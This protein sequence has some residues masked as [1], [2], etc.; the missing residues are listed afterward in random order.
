MKT[1]LPLLSAA[2]LTLSAA[3][4]SAQTAPVAPTPPVAHAAPA[5]ASAATTPLSVET[6]PIDELIKNPKAMEILKKHLPELAGQ[7]DQLAMAGSMTL[8]DVQA[9]AAESFTNEKLAAIE[10]DF[11]ALPAN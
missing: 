7:E 10:A 11:K 6:T 5:A 2:A 4:A 3:A 8:R 1:L 9:F